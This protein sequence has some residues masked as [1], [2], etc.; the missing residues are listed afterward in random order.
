MAKYDYEIKE[1]RVIV[2]ALGTTGYV[3]RNVTFGNEEQ[4]VEFAKEKFRKGHHVKIE[5]TLIMA[6]RM[7]E[8][9]R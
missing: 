3:I 9:G 2:Y 8:I 7:Y 6:T 5:K 1:Y 4:A